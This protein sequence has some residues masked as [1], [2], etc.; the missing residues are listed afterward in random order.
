MS[1]TLFHCTVCGNYS[2]SATITVVVDATVSPRLGIVVA[3]DI[4]RIG[5]I[6]LES[7]RY[8]FCEECGGLAELVCLDECPHKW[9]VL[10]GNNRMRLCEF[11]GEKQRGRT[12]L[13]KWVKYVQSLALYK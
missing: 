5:G 6:P 13:D 11:C 8:S 9:Q 7:I 10:F 1:V 12:M 3:F 4:L 2:D